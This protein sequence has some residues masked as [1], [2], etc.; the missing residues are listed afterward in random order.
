MY[1]HKAKYTS[2][3]KPRT[4]ESNDP[5]NIEFPVFSAFIEPDIML[6]GFNLSE[7]QVIGWNELSWQHLQSLEDIA[8]YQINFGKLLNLANPTGQ[9]RWGSNA[10]EMAAILLQK[11][12]LMAR[13]AQELLITDHSDLNF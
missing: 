9:A 4:L 2:T 1:A 11:P 12:V 5:Q 13:H 10:A 3:G 7:A 8:S 6:L